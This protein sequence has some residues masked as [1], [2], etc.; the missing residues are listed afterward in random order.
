MYSD[1]L[2]S[3]LAKYFPFIGVGRFLISKPQFWSSIVLTII[4]YVVPVLAF[5]LYKVIKKPTD[6]DK[7]S[8][9]GENKYKSY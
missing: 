6:T 5:R 1:G 9:L 8:S 7:V 3:I 2:Y 4:V